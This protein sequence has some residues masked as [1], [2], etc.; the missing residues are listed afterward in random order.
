MDVCSRMWVLASGT[1]ATLCLPDSRTVLSSLRGA[2]A[3]ICRAWP[4]REAGE[5][6]APPPRK[7]V[8]LPDQGLMS[9]G[10]GS[11]SC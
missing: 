4:G 11:I 3:A 5:P 8:V 10:L 6:M 9:T 1:V 2:K 7:R